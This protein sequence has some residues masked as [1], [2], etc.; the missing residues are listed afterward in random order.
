LTDLIIALVTVA[1]IRPAGREQGLGSPPYRMLDLAAKHYPVIV[2]LAYV[3]GPT[4]FEAAWP[5]GC[6]YSGH[7]TPAAAPNWLGNGKVQL[8]EVGSEDAKIYPG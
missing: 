3:D 2:D 8:P 1:A 5:S 4:P 7:S 6:W